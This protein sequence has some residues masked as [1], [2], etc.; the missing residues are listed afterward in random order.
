MI[1]WQHI[2]DRLAD[3]QKLY[4][5]TVIANSGSSPGRRGFKM[6]VAQD[7]F[8]FGSVGGGVMEFTLV[9]EA[10]ELLKEENPPT[11]IKR[12]IHRGKIKDGSGMICSGEQTIAFHCIDSN[13][14]AVINDIITYLEKGKKG[15]FSLTPDSLNFSS[16][17]SATHFKTQINSATDWLFEEQLGFQDTLYIV[18]GGHVG[19]AVS[20]VF[21][22]LGFYIVVFDNRENLNT[23]DNNLS[24]HQKKVVDYNQISEYIPPGTSSYVAIMTNTY[25]DDKLVLSKLIHNGYKYIGV[26][27]SKSKLKTLW[28]VMLQEGF[29]REELDKVHAPIGLSI[30]SETPEEIAV[31]IA[32][33]V[34]GVRNRRK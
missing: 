1:F 13:K 26:L 21:L 8:I 25:T 24:A 17:E 5:L 6:L 10:R 33:E 20:E 22:K 19:V 14:I 15:L 7:D 11:F 30:K 31:S 32:A 27:G 9:D 3:G 23:L 12:Q 28:K 4:V 34:I 18:G 29:S 2:A 16:E